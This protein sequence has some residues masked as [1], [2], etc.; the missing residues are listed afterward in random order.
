MTDT[1]PTAV[2]CSM[3]I[4]AYGPDQHI[5]Q[6]AQDF[7]LLESL[8]GKHPVIWINVEGSVS[9]EAL[10][11]FGEIFKLHPL[12]LEDVKNRQQRAKVEEFSDHHFVVTHMV[13]LN[14]NKLQTEQLSIFVGKDF[15]LTFQE[16]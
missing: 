9:W 5:E 15:V 6:T 11:K 14:D 1:P 7:T 3:Q 13:G 8:L 12:A 4:L 10:T 16:N 2:S